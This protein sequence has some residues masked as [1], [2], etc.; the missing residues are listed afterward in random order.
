MQTLV[1]DPG[2]AGGA[3]VIAQ[4]TRSVPGNISGIICRSSRR[5]SAAARSGQPVDAEDS[6]VREDLGF[7]GVRVVS[8]VVSVIV[9]LKGSEV[10]RQ[11]AVGG[12]LRVGN[13]P[14][15]VFTTHAPSSYASTS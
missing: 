9:Y 7:E 2:A 10:G 15:S 8:G 3:S 5:R 4:D 6:S 13:A 12:V 11:L 1:S 14:R